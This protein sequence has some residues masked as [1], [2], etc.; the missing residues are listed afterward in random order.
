MSCTNCG[1]RKPGELITYISKDMIKHCSLCDKVLDDEAIRFNTLGPCLT[2][3]NNI[4]NGER[5]DHYGNPEDSFALIAEYWEVYLKQIRTDLCIDEGCPHHGTD[6]I[7]NP[8]KLNAKDVA[9]MMMLF[10]LARC[11]GQESKR[12]N[13][14]DLCGYA[15]I[16]ADRLIS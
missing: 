5:Q 10:K 13:Y 9:H 4:I 12:D 8:H 11:S 2:E 3:A 6:H 7:C 1:L 14:V 15:S 16:V